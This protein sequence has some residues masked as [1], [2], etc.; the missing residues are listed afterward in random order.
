MTTEDLDLL[1]DEIE[2][3]RYD[4]LKARGWKHTCDWP[5]SI[6]LWSKEIKGQVVESDEKTA[7]HFER[8]IDEQNKP[9][10]CFECGSTGGCECYGK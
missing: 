2:T 10:T 8:T 6:W 4:F 5:G 7:M 9:E 1:R 3:K